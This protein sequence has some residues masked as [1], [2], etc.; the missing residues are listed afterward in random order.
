VDGP[1][2]LACG[3]DLEGLA[4]D[5]R[6]RAT[7]PECGAMWL[8]AFEYQRRRP[9]R[10][11]WLPLIVGGMPSALV[12]VLI[13]GGRYG[14]WGMTTPD[15]WAAATRVG[16]LGG[17]ALGGL[18]SALL[19]L[20]EDRRIGLPLSRRA[21]VSRWFVAFII[22]ALIIAAVAYPLGFLAT[23]LVYHPPPRL[24]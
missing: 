18:A 9:V 22:L 13:L 14:V 4:L 3:Y 5:S 1:R 12:L 20:L 16:T 23:M 19:M 24:Y 17:A 11:R 15:F 2:C 7:C 21:F 6:G 8:P 10:I